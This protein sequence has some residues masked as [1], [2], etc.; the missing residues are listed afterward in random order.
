MAYYDYYGGEDM[1]D[2]DQQS[3]DSLMDLS[4][5]LSEVNKKSEIMELT[6]RVSELT[7]K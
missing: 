3:H 5:Q 4:T 1:M 7:K 2:T 6:T